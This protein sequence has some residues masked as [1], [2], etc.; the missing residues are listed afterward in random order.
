MNK[1]TVKESGINDIFKERY[2]NDTVL[3][4]A[5]SKDDVPSVRCVDTFY[6]DESFWIVTDLRCNYVKDIQA[7]PFVMISDGGHN[8]FWCKAEIT[9]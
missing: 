2:S 3:L 8:R 1:T 9:G 6:Y 7:N 4:V 5:T